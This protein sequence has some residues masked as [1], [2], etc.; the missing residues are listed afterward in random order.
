MGAF[1]KPELRGFANRL[2]LHTSLAWCV[3]ALVASAVCA[4]DG[5]CDRLPD[6]VAQLQHANTLQPRMT[7][8]D[9]AQERNSFWDEIVAAWNQVMC[10][11]QALDDLPHE[12][13]GNI[14][15]A[16]NASTY[17]FRDT[18]Y[19]VGSCRK[20]TAQ[21]FVAWL[22]QQ[23]VVRNTGDGLDLTF[24]HSAARVVPFKRMP[25]VWP[26]D[27]LADSFASGTLAVLN[28]AYDHTPGGGHITFLGH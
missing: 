5:E 20:D 19:R 22:Q 17:T 10:A 11:V 7:K 21:R 13:Y 1:A 18:Q 9:P 25:T 2:R 28:W 8:Y 3:E 6:I 27:P 4:V 14:L 23:A 12:F 26:L 15:R 24:R 16:A